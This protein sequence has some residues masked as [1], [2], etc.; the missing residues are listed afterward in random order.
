MKT[1]PEP[2]NQVAAHAVEYAAA[3]TLGFYRV[4]GEQN[5]ELSARVGRALASFHSE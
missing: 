2:K 4:C 3:A 1:I 5:L